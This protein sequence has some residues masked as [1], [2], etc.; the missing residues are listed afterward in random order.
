M[1]ILRIMEEMRFSNVNLHSILGKKPHTHPYISKNKI[2]AKIQAACYQLSMADESLIRASY[3]LGWSVLL[4]INLLMWS[5]LPALLF[6]WQ[7]FIFDS[8]LCMT[9]EYT[10]ADG[11]PLHPLEPLMTFT[12]PLTRG[13]WKSVSSLILFPWSSM[14]YINTHSSSIMSLADVAP[15]LSNVVYGWVW[16]QAQRETHGKN[17]DLKRSYF[18]SRWL[19]KSTVSERVEF[20]IFSRCWST[21]GLALFWC[22]PI[23][24]YFQSQKSTCKNRFCL[25]LWLLKNMTKLAWLLDFTWMEYLHL[26]S[27]PF[28][29]LTM[30]YKLTQ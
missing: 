20:Q 16:K 30:T 28:S 21:S 24:T 23:F 17:Q 8:Q 19:C 18:S 14:K 29:P 9:N 27:M 5:T 13:L 10:W 3:L 4:Q 25:P 6:S 26:C 1:A 7:T 2:R 15:S 11:G 22:G 12:P